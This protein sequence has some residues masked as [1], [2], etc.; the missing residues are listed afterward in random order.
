MA[1]NFNTSTIV[2]VAGGGTYAVDIDSGVQHVVIRPAGAITLSADVSVTVSGTPRL[3]QYIKF[4]YAGTITSNTTSGFTVN[5]FGT[6]LT[7]NQALYEAEI[8]AIYNGSAWEMHI[9]SDEQAGNVPIDGGTIGAGTIPGSA[10]ADDAVG[11]TQMADITRGSLIVGEASDA[12]TYLDVSGSAKILMGDGTDL[13]SVAMSGD[14]T[15][16]SS[17]VTEIGAGKITDAMLAN[18]PQSY[19]VANVTITS[20]QILAGCTTVGGTAISV[21]PAQ[22]TN[23]LIE[24]ISCTGY[25]NYSTAAYAAGGVIELTMG[26]GG[27]TI[28]SASAALLTT[29]AVGTEQFALDTPLLTSGL[30]TAI[31]FDNATATFTTGGYDLRLSII[32]RVIDFS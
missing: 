29:A 30:N 23:K 15:I 21:I 28:A 1:N 20:A 19:S 2:P 18:T 5:I 16:N 3:N 8:R 24:V 12:P 6:A 27:T 25:A 11:L 10:L 14:V 9:C 32:Y 7:D 31:F 13:T 4:M 22:G 17:G 26:D